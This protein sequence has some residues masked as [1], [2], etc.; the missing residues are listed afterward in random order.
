ML[1]KVSRKDCYIESYTKDIFPPHLSNVELLTGIRDGKLYQGTFRAS[2]DNFL[3]GF[4][5]V[6]GFKDMVSHS[7][8]FVLF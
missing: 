4:I 6:D 7:K 5:N 1:D 2:R 8:I 3:E